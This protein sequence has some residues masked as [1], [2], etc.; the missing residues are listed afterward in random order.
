MW[1]AGQSGTASPQTHALAAVPSLSLTSFTSPLSVVAL[2]L[3]MLLMFRRRRGL[4][5]YN[6]VG[7]KNNACVSTE[8]MRTVGHFGAICPPAFQPVVE[9]AVADPLIR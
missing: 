1:Y 8:M 3:V 5:I 4:K 9:Y 6:F 2:S 7:R